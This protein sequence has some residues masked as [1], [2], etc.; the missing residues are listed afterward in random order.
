MVA[1]P[2]HADAPAPLGLSVTAV[3]EQ[4]ASGDPV[5]LTARVTNRTGSSCQLATVP[6]GALRIVGMTKNG[7]PVSPYF[8]R[9][10]YLEGYGAYLGAHLSTVSSDDAVTVSLDALPLNQE[11]PGRRPAAAF[12]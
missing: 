7:S 1:A 5:A 4:F 3:S 10:D 8:G 11:L 6:D 2:A 9:A 12:R